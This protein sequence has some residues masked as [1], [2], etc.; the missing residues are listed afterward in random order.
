M[1]A[2]IIVSVRWSSIKVL[3]CYSYVILSWE[4]DADVFSLST[5]GDDEY[6]LRRL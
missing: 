5:E 4:T 1:I 6:V 3:R 2:S